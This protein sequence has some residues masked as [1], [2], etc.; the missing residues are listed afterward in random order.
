LGGYAIAEKQSIDAL[1]AAMHY[2]VL[3]KGEEKKVLIPRIHYVPLGEFAS[4][5]N[6]ISILDN[7]DGSDYR[8]FVYDVQPTPSKKTDGSQ[9]EIQPLQ[10]Q[11]LSPDLEANFFLAMIHLWHHNYEEAFKQLVGYGGQQRPFSPEEREILI[12]GLNAPNND[13]TPESDAVRLQA[14]I[15]LMRNERNFGLKKAAPDKSMFIRLRGSLETYE[16]FL[17]HPSSWGQFQLRLDDEL[18]LLREILSLP[19]KDMIRVSNF[20]EESTNS[21]YQFLN[22]R[23]EQLKGRIIQTPK[24]SVIK[25]HPASHPLLDINEERGIDHL[26]WG[27]VRNTGASRDI[28]LPR[29]EKK[30]ALEF[31]QAVRTRNPSL[32]Q[33]MLKKIMDIDLPNSLNS[34]ELI[35]DLDQTLEFISKQPPTFTIVNSPNRDTGT[36]NLALFLKNVLKYPNPT[37]LPETLT[38]DNRDIL[39]EEIESILTLTDNTFNAKDSGL[40]AFFKNFD[41]SQILNFFWPTEDIAATPTEAIHKAATVTEESTS[42]EK[43]QPTHNLTIP[44]VSNLSEFHIDAAV[45]NN[46][47]RQDSAA[48]INSTR[49][50][51]ANDINIATNNTVANRVIAK[52]HE[53]ISSYE[54][55]AK[56]QGYSI[57][58]WP[59]LKALQTTVSQEYNDNSTSLDSLTQQIETLIQKEPLDPKER[60]YRNLEIAIKRK[61]PL[62][63]DDAIYLYLKHSSETFQELNPALDEADQN[64]FLALMHR[65]LIESTNQQHRSRILKDIESI[66]H[67]QQSK[68]LDAVP[69][70]LKDNLGRSLFSQR[71]YDPVVHP[72]YLVLEHFMDITLWDKQVKA[73]DTLLIKEGKITARENLGSAIELIMGS[74]KTDVLLPLICLLNADGENLAIGIVP[75]VLLAENAAELSNRVGPAFRQALDVVT[76]NQALRLDLKE[77]TNLYDR[78]D[79]AIKARRIV[80]MSDSDVQGLFLKFA[81]A[82]TNAVRLEG[83]ELQTKLEEIAEFRKIFRLLHNQGVPAIDEPD[84]IFNAKLSQHQTKGEPQRLPD[85]FVEGSQAFMLALNAQATAVTPFQEKE[86]IAEHIAGVTIQ[87]TR[88]TPFEKDSLMATYLSGLNN[89][90]RKIIASF[91]KGSND[92]AII[93]FIDDIPKKYDANELTEGEK[94]QDIL[95]IIREQISTLAPLIFSKKYRFDFAPPISEKEL[96]LTDKVE[97][98]FSIP[99]KKGNPSIGSKPGTELEEVLYTYR[100]FLLRKQLP[101]TFFKN[102]IEDLRKKTIAESASMHKKLKDIPAYMELLFMFGDSL[103]AS[104]G[105]PFNDAFIEAGLVAQAADP[106]RLTSFIT[107]YIIKEIQFYPLQLNSNSQFYRFL[108]QKGSE[109]AFSGTVWNGESW[110]WLFGDDLH[111]SDT[112]QKTLTL[113]YQGPDKAVHSLNLAGALMATEAINEIYT[114]IPESTS[115]IDGSGDLLRFDPKEIATCMLAHKNLSEKV[116]VRYPDKETGLWMEIERGKTKPVLVE[117]SK[118]SPSQVSV[119]WPSPKTTGSDIRTAPDE[120][121]TVILGRNTILRDIQQTLWRLREYDKG[122]TARFAMDSGDEDIVRQNLGLITGHP[123]TGELQ[124]KHALQNEAYL[125]AMQVGDDNSRSLKSRLDAALMHRVWD[126]MLDPALSDQE[127]VN[128]MQKAQ[129]LYLSNTLSRP[130]HMYGKPKTLRPREEVATEWLNNS[131][132]SPVLTALAPIDQ[133]DVTNEM[134]AIHQKAVPTLPSHLLAAQQYGFEREVEVNTEV[135]VEKETDKEQEKETEVDAIKDYSQPIH[136]KWEVELFPWKDE[137]LFTEVY[138]SHRIL[139]LKSASAKLTPESQPIVPLGLFVSAAAKSG[140]FYPTYSSSVYSSLNFSPIHK[141]PH[142]LAVPYSRVQEYPGVFIVIQTDRGPQSLLITETEERRFR[143]LLSKDRLNKGSGKRDF[144]VAIYDLETGVASQSS[145]PIDFVSLEKNPEFLLQKVQLKFYAGMSHYTKEELPILQGWIESCGAENMETYFNTVV[146]TNDRSD[147]R[148]AFR[149]STLN[150][151]FKDLKKAK[152]IQSNT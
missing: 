91:L 73:L 11:L 10:T 17:N 143:E 95:S 1:G 147:S 133:Q 70:K 134:G 71:A 99:H 139:S 111:L 144:K 42:V 100:Q 80:M 132:K 125:Q 105:Q 93:K 51:L 113:I 102:V 87:E 152:K 35:N 65:Y 136:E 78:L 67:I 57:K 109:T 59:A 12:N 32:M 9:V 138:F 96:D 104:L 62:N 145:E 2:L 61:N 5:L 150:N 33:D 114:K 44:R 129:P 3:E 55:P 63:I 107:K 89:D 88:G 72:E 92:P 23:L 7:K 48:S 22:K 13:A 30:E 130:Y 38:L 19:K 118:L 120:V 128:I 83:K 25:S 31:Y 127:V 26:V 21:F 4:S 148:K 142:S 117:Q 131:L 115:I 58:D 79:Y 69:Q 27:Y 106:Q 86:E 47:M 52:L 108:F 84:T 76:I 66:D 16:K 81:D 110:P 45:A 60:A 37:S 103:P 36:T 77:L 46:L 141:S 28:L 75:K 34:E 137:G 85:S 6:P 40:L 149:H 94:I 121:A 41:P 29:F 146:L 126:R 122:Q 119:Y 56:A 98:L 20:N 90:Q 43:A 64:A 50:E 14:S 15:M 74:G 151:I 101:R 112:A 123:I 8:Y 116:A 24:V 68:G 82:N 124:I 18:F 97:D 140:D 54:G 135:K 39:K 53:D 49:A